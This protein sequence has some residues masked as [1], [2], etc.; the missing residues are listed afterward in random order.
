MNYA[1]W[2]PADQ[3]HRP[4]W[5]KSTERLD[6]IQLPDDRQHWP[7]PFNWAGHYAGAWPAGDLPAP[8]GATVLTGPAWRD[9]D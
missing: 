7:Q 3:L 6:R 9:H 8:E 1:A 4:L 2:V 5:A